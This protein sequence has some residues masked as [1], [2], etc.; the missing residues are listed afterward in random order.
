MSPAT[1]TQKLWKYATT[2]LADGMSYGDYVEQLTYLL[3]LKMADERARPP[4][5]LES[6][7]PKKYNWESL[8]KKDGSELS[9]HYDDALRVMSGKSGVLGL[10]FG[11]A[12]NRFKTPARLQSIIADLI[13]KEEWSAM[14]ADVIGSA[15]EGLLEKNA[16]DVKS[17]AGQYFTPRPLINAIV[18]AMTP[19]PGR[20]VCDPACGTGGFLLAAHDYVIAK[21]RVMEARQKRVLKESTFFGCELVNNTARLCAINLLLHRIGDKNEPLVTDGDSLLSPSA[22]KYDIVLT[23]PPFLSRTD[24]KVARD[25]F[26][27]A[28]GK[29][30]LNFVQHVYSMLKLD[31]R[32]VMMLPT[33]CFLKAG[34]AKQYAVIC[35][36][37]AMFIPCCACQRAFFIDQE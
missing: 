11:G 33:M 6:P 32:A 30:Q 8:L 31:G 3:F 24:G 14:R 29:Q 23:N 21:N 28:T 15:Y 17:G 7:I 4:Y 25:D 22:K 12:Q 5:N 35:Y 16:Q 18:E 20:T 13:D 26:W 37:S 36:N 34:R 10:I 1:I 27:T 9:A 19:S 2:L